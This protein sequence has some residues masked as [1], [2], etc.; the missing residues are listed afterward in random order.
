MGVLAFI[1]IFV[2]GTIIGSFLNVVIFRYNTGRSV[3]SGRSQCLSCSK[4]LRWHELIPILSFLIQGGRCRKCLSR[5]S[6]QYPAVE[7]LTG[8][9]FVL[10]VNL[11]LPLELTLLYF[12]IFS[13]LLVIT[14]YDLRHKIIPDGLVLAFAALSLLRLFLIS[15]RLAPPL[16]GFDWPVFAK[17]IV[18]GVLLFSALGLIWFLSR[19]RLM[20]LGDAKLAL[21]TGLLLGF[22]G[23]VSALILAFWSGAAAGLLLILLS[24]LSRRR[25]YFTIKSEMPFA[26]FIIFGV[27][28]NLFFHLDV[29]AFIK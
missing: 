12:V 19:G 3:V 6:A 26:P 17:G 8:L 20:G 15:V 14:A 29:L 28:L 9:L 4:I 27:L 5:I 23:G 22:H 16:A 24:R 18:S 13:L 11:G 21:G 25:S 2:L 1:L 10:I 7:L